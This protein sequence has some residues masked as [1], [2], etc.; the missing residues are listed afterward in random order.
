M[1]YRFHA[2]AA[3]FIYMLRRVLADDHCIIYLPVDYDKVGKRNVAIYGDP[4]IVFDWNFDLLVY[5]EA[6]LIANY[7]DRRYSLIIDAFREATPLFH[8]KYVVTESFLKDFNIYEEL[9]EP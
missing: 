2:V 5:F 9:I 1:G 4:Y 8:K 7:N 3:D 6:S